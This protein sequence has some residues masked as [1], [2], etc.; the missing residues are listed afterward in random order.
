MNISSI[1]GLFCLLLLMPMIYGVSMLQFTR[2]WVYPSHFVWCRD[3]LLDL[4]SRTSRRFDQILTA[5]WSL[6]LGPFLSHLVTASNMAWISQRFLVSAKVYSPHE[7]HIR[8]LQQ[9]KFTNV[10]TMYEIKT[11]TSWVFKNKQKTE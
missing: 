1:L 11:K 8:Y 4:S 6:C 2:V 7:D 3:S 5:I 10:N 9:Q